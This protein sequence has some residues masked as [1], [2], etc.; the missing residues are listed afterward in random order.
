MSEVPATDASAAR[1]ADPPPIVEF[2]DVA[3][4]FGTFTAVRDLN[5]RIDDHPDRGEFIAIIGPSGC[6]KSTLLNLVAGFLQPSAGQVLVRGE[7]V[8][9]PGRDR[10]M[11][12]QQ[13]SSFPH[14]TV[15][16]NVL[17]GLSIN[18]SDL[19]LS[20]AQQQERAMQLIGQVGLAGHEH[21]YPHQ[22]SGGQQQ[23]VAI[24]RT[25]ALEP[26]ILLMDEPFSALDEPT[27]LEMQELTV[28]LWHRIH[29]TIFCI[30]HS[31]TE[32]V[33]LG[34]RVFIFTQAPGQIA[35]DIHDCIPPTHG[36]PPLEAQERPEFKDAVRIV[37]EAF[38]RVC[39]GRIGPG[40]RTECL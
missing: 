19:K 22:L 29:P 13:Y 24:A 3:V 1:A 20:K 4:R 30:T 37:T 16:G 12:F 27:R 26:R 34:D 15:L 32:A 25:L 28:D 9:E 35:Y 23:R 39:E 5:F 38:R 8:S 40:D 6:G 21:K 31:V 2:R 33:Y 14:L 10:G 18:R 7:A 36:V 11:I 17:F